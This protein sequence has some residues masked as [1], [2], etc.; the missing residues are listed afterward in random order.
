VARLFPQF[1]EEE[2]VFDA[3]QLRVEAP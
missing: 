3:R 1:V 2:L